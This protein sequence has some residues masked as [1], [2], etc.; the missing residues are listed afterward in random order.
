MVNFFWSPSSTKRSTK[1][2]RKI[3]GKF[4]AKFGAEFGTKIR[5]IRKLSFCNFSGLKNTVSRVLFRNREL[6]EFCSKLA[7]FCEKLGEFA[8]AHK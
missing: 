5:K 2:P 7:E 6:T 1:S 4:G 8:V 3:R